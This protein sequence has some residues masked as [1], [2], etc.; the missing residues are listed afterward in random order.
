MNEYSYKLSCCTTYA[1]PIMPETY[2]TFGCI[3]Q[4]ASGEIGH[5]GESVVSYVE[6][7]ACITGAGNATTQPRLERERHVSGMGMM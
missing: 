1:L 7:T 2:V 6:Q 4:M 3:C 5:H